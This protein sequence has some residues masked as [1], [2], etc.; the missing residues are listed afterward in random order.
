[1]DWELVAGLATVHNHAF[2]LGVVNLVTVQPVLDVL[3]LITLQ[4]NHLRALT[5]LDD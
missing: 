4:L 2:I 1:M 3:T 5:V